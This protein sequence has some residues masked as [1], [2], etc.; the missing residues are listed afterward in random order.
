LFSGRVSLGI[1]NALSAL[2]DERRPTIDLTVSNPTRVGI[3]YPRELI[4]ALADARGLVYEPS[5]RGLRAA[6]EAIGGGRVD[7]DDIVL[8]ASTSEAYSWLFKLLCD[9]GDAVLVPEPSYP[10]FA[11]LAALEAVTLAPYPLA[12]DGAWHID[13]PSL[14]V[15]ARARA[16]VA[17]SPNNPTGSYLRQEELARL[18]ATGLPLVVDEVFADYPLDDAARVTLAA[19]EP[20][21][22]IFSLGGLSKSVGLPQLKLAWI[23]AG[24]ERRRDA[25]E[26][27]EH[28]ADGYLSVA[29]PV[30]LAAPRLLEAG[31]AIRARILA[32]VRDS[33]A[34]IAARVAGTAVTLLHAEGGWSAIL[35]CPAVRT[36]EELALALLREHGVLVHPGYFFDLDGTHLVVSLLTPPGDL[37]RGL[38]AILST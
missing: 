8:C 6:R 11:Q 5:A 4:D 35:R 15:P 17:V 26:R 18:A 20:A 10:L 37:A 22:L 2:L 12:Y 14:R 23:V 29:T 36:D 34:R 38:D 25:L 9:P 19:A 13:L 3:E 30:Q 33:R 28:I 21:P 7:P 32:R 1:R 16:I 31:A 24:G 27:L